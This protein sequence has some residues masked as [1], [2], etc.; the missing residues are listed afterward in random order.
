MNSEAER[1][2]IK[3]LY[4]SIKTISE[5]VDVSIYAPLTLLS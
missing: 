3:A 5:L 1:E 2:Q 4:S